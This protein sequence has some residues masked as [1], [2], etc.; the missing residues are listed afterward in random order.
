MSP[1]PEKYAAQFLELAEKY[2]KD[3]AAVDAL[4]WVVNNTWR[5]PGKAARDKA[6][7]LLTRDHIGSDKLGMVCENLLFGGYEKQKETFLAKNTH[8][9]VQAEAYL[10]LAQ[11]LQLRARL[12]KLLAE[13]PKPGV[14]QIALEKEV[15]AEL[16]TADPT[17]LDADSEQAFREF[18]DQHA[19]NMK[20]ER[21]ASFCRQLG[22]STDKGSQSL[23][24]TLLEKDKRREAQGV[25]CVALG[26]SLKMQADAD[27][28][29]DPKAAAKLR[30]ECEALFERA[31][32]D[33]ADVKLAFRGT[34]GEK[35]KTELYEIHHLAIGLK[36][37]DVAGEDQDGKKFKLSDYQGKVVL[38]DFWSEF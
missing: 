19:V 11:T 13:D 33:Y 20:P 38:L 36:A 32:K 35:A 9:G 25:A 4:V 17:K 10:A 29:K 30:A 8:K 22:F 23:L 37:P 12:A 3:P 24:R 7:D 1:K 31:A 18:V 14:P 28:D 6:F 2:T 27:A 16:K 5:R 34:V 21:I 15:I 26:Q